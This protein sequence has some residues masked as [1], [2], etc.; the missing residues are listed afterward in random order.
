M[1]NLTIRKATFDDLD[2][3]VLSM[4]KSFDK[5]LFFNW[6]VRRDKKRKKGLEQLF[7]T[8]LKDLTLPYNEVVTPDNCCGGGL[9]MPM[10]KVKLS[11]TKQLKLVIPIIR[12]AGFSGLVRVINALDALE[13]AHPMDKKHLYFFFL[14]VDPDYQKRGLASAMIK[15]M[16]DRCDRDGLGAYCECTNEVSKA[17][18]ESFGFKMQGELYV[19]KDA[20]KL[21]AMW[22]DA[23]VN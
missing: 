12:I 6:L 19:A 5:D 10:D 13:K 22:R 4:T 16:L 1:E 18:C 11:F 20:P 3:M 2:R 14:G 8:A 17:L 15:T 9:W 23:Q 21:F 7:R